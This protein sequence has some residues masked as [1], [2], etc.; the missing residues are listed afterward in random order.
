L[1]LLT[2]SA[3]AE[4]LAEFQRDWVVPHRNTHLFLAQ[5]ID[6]VDLDY[7]S[8][9]PQLFS[10]PGV[11]ELAA[12]D[13]PDT[14][15]QLLNNPTWTMGFTLDTTSYDVPKP[16]VLNLNSS[17][18]K[19]VL[20]VEI[21]TPGAVTDSIRTRWSIHGESNPAPEPSAITLFGVA[22]A[23]IMSFGHHHRGRNTRRVGPETLH[24]DV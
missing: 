19:Y 7:Q 2:T 5:T 10:L 24:L 3:K 13:H 18:D 21:L 11:Y 9:I 15:S 14:T 6:D 4:V 17:I 8:A 20:T 22:I 23:G 1:A 12:A 16:S